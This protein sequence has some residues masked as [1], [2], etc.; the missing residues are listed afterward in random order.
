MSEPT[1]IDPYVY[2]PLPDDPAAA[3]DAQLG[4]VTP[5]EEE[6]NYE[7]EQNARIK[8]ATTASAIAIAKE[9]AHAV[10]TLFPNGH[11][12]EVR[13]TY[14]FGETH[15]LVTGRA[16]RLGETHTYRVVVEVSAELIEG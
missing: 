4:P 9:Y 1:Q 15:R 3:I 11:L 12:D 8:A 14:G 16:Y 5:T 2:P 6:L 10:T 13:T 7:A